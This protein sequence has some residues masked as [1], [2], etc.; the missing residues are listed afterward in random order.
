MILTDTSI[1]ID[2]LRM[3]TLPVAR[4][5][6][7]EQPAICGITVAELYAGVRSPAEQTDLEATLRRFGNVPIEEPVWELTGRISGAMAR[8]GTKVKFQDAVIAATAI[9]AK[10]P[11]WCR[12]VHFTWIQ[13]AFPELDL[14]DDTTA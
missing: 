5:V 3:P 13:T 12:D 10:V 2:W 11:L 1:L 4:V 8:R 7:S 6:A 9:H 14:F